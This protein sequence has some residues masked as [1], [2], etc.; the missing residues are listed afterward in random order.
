MKSCVTVSRQT[1]CV[2]DE[3]ETHLELV[4]GGWLWRKPVLG[5]CAGTTL[6]G[7]PMLTCGSQRPDVSI[8]AQLAE[9]ENGISFFHGCLGFSNFSAGPLSLHW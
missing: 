8:L 3:V 6:L 4:P 9:V 2:E 1:R 7:M 5:C